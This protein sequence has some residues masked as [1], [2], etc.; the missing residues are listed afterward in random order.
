MPQET[1][2]LLIQRYQTIRSKTEEL[3]E[4]LQAED[5]MLQGMPDTS[6]A[7][8]HIAHTSWFFETF[9]L[10][11]FLDG[12][13]CFH[14]QYETLFNSYYNH[15]GQPFLRANRGLLSR[16]GIEEIYLYRQKINEN[17]LALLDR[18]NHPHF[19]EIC[20]LIE[21]GLNHEQQHQELLLTDIKYNFSLNPLLP[22]YKAMPEQDHKSDNARTAALPLDFIEV[23]GG[24]ISSGLD[25]QSSSFFFDNE[26]PDHKV[27]IND[28]SVANRLTTNGEYLAFIE[29]GGYERHELWLA[30]AWSLLQ[31]E[32]WSAPL[33]WQI[34][35]GR[36]YEFTLSGL[37]PLDLEQPV[38]HV[39]YYEADAYARWCGQ[40]LLT[41]SQWEHLASSQVIAGNFLGGGQLQP[42][43][44][45]Q[46]NSSRITD[47]NAIKQ[48]FGDVW[49]WTQSS[50]NAYPGFRPA[51]GAVGEYNGK[52][53]CNQQILRGG[54]CVSEQQHLRSTYRNFFYPSAR[55]QFSG[56]RTAKNH[57]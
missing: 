1:T 12:Y 36:R 13:Q 5:Y 11:S 22:A 26:T 14:P 16:P 31:Q 43:V 37:Q 6:P 52:F 7:K 50:Y 23:T 39:S 25:P 19:H 29:D 27:F 55:W 56:I 34:S 53:M 41:E 3:C 10:K 18:P 42:K 24:L 49:E 2:K 47:N 17:I 48:L 35:A 32:H 45:L 15:V 30:D 28:F 4:P 44:A 9:V 51:K 54:S 38:T 33:Y 8:W 40:E 21:L 57:S 20:K 46:N